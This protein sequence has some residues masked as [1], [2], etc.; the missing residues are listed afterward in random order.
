MKVSNDRVFTVAWLKIKVLKITTAETTKALQGTSRK[1][2]IK[3]GMHI[4]IK[5]CARSSPLKNTA[6]AATM[7]VTV[8]MQAATT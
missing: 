5:V 1:L 7:S 6:D 3:T 2:A 8:S 4:M